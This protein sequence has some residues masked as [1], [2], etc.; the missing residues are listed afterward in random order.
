LLQLSSPSK[1]LVSFALAV[2]HGLMD[3]YLLLLASQD[4]TEVSEKTTRGRVNGSQSKFSSRTW[5]I[6]QNQPETPLF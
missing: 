1:Y 4:K 6:S 5:S 3:G 2:Q